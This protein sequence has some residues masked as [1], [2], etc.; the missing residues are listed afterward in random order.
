MWPVP[1]T[2]SVFCML[3]AHALPPKLDNDLPCPHLLPPCCSGLNDVLGPIMNLSYTDTALNAGSAALGLSA[4]RHPGGAVANYWSI[5]NGSY[6]GADGTTDGCSNGTYW[7]YCAYAHRGDHPAGA[8]SAASFTKGV[9]ANK[10]IIW[11]L[12]VFT[13][14]LG[15]T[16]AAGLYGQL[17]PH[18][19]SH[20]VWQ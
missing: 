13:L 14:S 4:L 1:L 20:R 15:S 11:V 7:N 16:G 6:V 8:F 19:Q 18:G 12:N 3:Q 17:R 5:V 9:G 10:E 2:V